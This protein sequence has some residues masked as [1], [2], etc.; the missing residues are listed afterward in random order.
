LLIIDFNT[1]FNSAYLKTVY[2]KY[3]DIRKRGRFFFD[4]LIQRIG[5]MLTHTTHGVLHACSPSLKSLGSSKPLSNCIS[6]F[7]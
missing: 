3:R 6:N 4:K 7:T 2:K 1:G 5:Q